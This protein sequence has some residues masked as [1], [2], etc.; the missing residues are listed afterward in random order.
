MELDRLLPALSEAFL[1]TVFVQ[2]DDTFHPIGL[3]GNDGK[4]AFVQIGSSSQ[5]GLYFIDDDKVFR[6]FLSSENKVE[7]EDASLSVHPIGT[8]N[9]FKGLSAKDFVQDGED[10]RLPFSTALLY[11]SLFVSVSVFY[12]ISSDL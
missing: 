5:D 10:F 8:V 6:L 3:F 4:R 12:H 11:R 9:P 1:S 2:Q 7:K